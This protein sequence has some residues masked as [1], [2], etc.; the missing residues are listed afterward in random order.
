MAASHSRKKTPLS[1]QDR[2]YRRIENSGLVSTV[3]K[4]AE[5]DL[6]ILAPLAV[7]DQ[8]LT[9]IAEA[10]AVI[11][12]YIG[13]NPLFLNSLIPLPQDLQAPEVIQQMLT[14]GI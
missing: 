6:H 5:T 14:S 2:A 10:R 4:M 13:N 1:Y 9:A 11:E 12:Q 7:G 3:V 8:A